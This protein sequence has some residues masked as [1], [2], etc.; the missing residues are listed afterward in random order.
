MTTQSVSAVPEVFGIDL[1]F[2]PRAYFLPPELDDI[3]HLAHIAGQARREMARDL[4]AAGDD[5]VPLE[6]L[7]E[8]LD[9]VTRT[10][11][12]K[13]HPA[14]MGGEYLPNLTPTEV[15][16]ARIVIASTTRDVTSVYARRGKNRIYYRVVDEYEGETMSEKTTRSSTWPLALGELE[17]FLNGA[18]SIFDV[19]A[20]NFGRDGYVIED[21][22]AFVNVDSQFYPQI[23]ELYRRRIEA[24]A[25][26]RRAARSLNQA[27]AVLDRAASAKP[28]E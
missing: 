26:V 25:D 21:M 2:R 20:M 27:K 23:D 14:F 18:W 10:A 15:E 5:D 9:D 1:E 13:I 17:A 4:L 11:I 7:A 3:T 19:L 16:I 8:L 22:L 6:L 28:H 24:W 12:G